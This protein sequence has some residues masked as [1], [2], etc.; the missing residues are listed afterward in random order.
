MRSLPLCALA[1]L[2]AARNVTYDSRSYILDGKRA[3]LLSGSI[4]Y[5]R[6]EPSDWARVLSLAAE[7]HFNTIQTYVLWDQH[8]PVQGSISWSGRNNITAF[9][10]LAQSFGLNVV[11]RIGPYI[12]GEHFN[13]G[14]PLWMR[15]VEGSGASCFR[16]ADPVWEGFSTHVLSAV[17]GELSASSLLFPQGGPVIMLQVENEY[18]GDIKYLTD[19]VDAARNVTTDVPWILCHD[20]DLCSAV[21]ANGGAMGKAVCTINGFWEDDSAEGD[22]QPSPSFVKKQ[23][24]NNP[25]QP[26][27]WTE[28]QGWFDQWG[29]AQRVRHPSDILYGVA[30]SVSLGFTHHNF[31]MLTGGSNFAYSAADA[32]TTAYAPDTAIDFLL[33]R[34]EPKF[35]TFAAFQASLLSVA[36]EILSVDPP[37]PVPIGANV[38]TATFG[39][40]VFISNKGVSANDTQIVSVAGGSWL[41]PNHTVVL[42]YNGALLFNTSAAPDVAPIFT[43]PRSATAPP[44]WVTIAESLGFGNN[45]SAAPVG[46]PPLEMLNFTHA[47][48]DYMYY[49]LTPAA[50]VNATTLKVSTCGG[51]YVY[52]FASKSA[53]AHS[54]ARL[55]SRRPNE[56]IFSLPAGGAATIHILVSAMGLSTG[57][58]PKSCKGVVKVVA[59]STD[60][61]NEGWASRW[62]FKGEAEKVFTQAGAA[63]AVWSPVP[64]DGGDV[65]T[66]WFKTT[67]DLPPPPVGAFDVAPGAEPQ[68]AYALDLL[69]ATKGVAW[70]NG[71]NIGRYNLELGVCTGDCAPPHH[72]TQCYIY[73]RNCGLPTQR[74][75]HVPSA[76][77]RPTGNLV[78]LFEETAT[79]PVAGQGPAAPS[80]PPP[81]PGK[82]AQSALH[83]DAAASGTPRNL[84]TVALVALD[85]HP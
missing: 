41:I 29:V 48:V 22:S 83:A 60:L 3:L 57:P 33:L 69:G 73:W 19:V 34:H 38:E 66:S 8:E 43:A 17:V 61:S 84:A 39:G 18:N 32:V 44:T 2:A 10:S 7:A 58:S 53:A 51:E 50:P 65:P 82:A 45:S 67:F 80:P 4:H 68:L 56:H 12:C 49:S 76:I 37:T 74:F 75:Y 13:G 9:A 81:R 1:A 36:D 47:L 11:V 77:L 78:V 23:R 5:Q 28:D 46:S 35:S 79:V 21:N 24:E 55:V 6:V 85:A 16:C 31:Y 72:G 63:A 62:V 40:V 70:V 14:I 30:R 54:A 27:S 15:T 71:F 64:P 20:E 25:N 42:L 52:V 59:G 26:L